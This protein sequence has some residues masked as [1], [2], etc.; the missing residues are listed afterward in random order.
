MSAAMEDEAPSVGAFAKYDKMGE[1][2][3]SVGAAAL[4]A[5]TNRYVVTEKVHGAN[6]CLIARSLGP[7]SVD[8]KFAKRTA[9][10]GGVDDAEDFYSCRSTGLLR[11]LA[12]CAEHVLRAVEARISGSNGALAVHIYGELFGGKYPHPEVPSVPGLEPVQC[13]VWYSPSLQFMAFDVCVELPSQPRQFIDFDVARHL[14]EAGGL[15]FA[16]PLCEGTLAECLDF[17]YEFVTTIPGLLGLPDMP[18]DAEEGRNVAEGV[19][20]RPRQEPSSRAS[21]SSSKGGGKESARGLFKRKIEAFSEKR[22]QNDDWRK[23]KAGGGGAAP[24]VNEDEITLIEIQ[25]CVTEQRLAAVMSKI[26]RVDPLDKASLARLL[27]DFEADVMEA[28][29][30]A[31]AGRLRQS[32]ALQEHLRQLSKELINQDFKRRG[33]KA[34]KK[35][36]SPK[37][38]A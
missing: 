20:V 19:V 17:S 13:G 33:V 37:S 10:L 16:Q 11:S 6:F 14:C 3:G 5:S 28:L 35:E 15:R 1:D 9:I 36:G 22:Y 12:P 30:E 25:A 24:T 21:A 18:E 38:S 8:L 31:D 27:S 7:A 29:E 2:S 4:S 26:G 23:G 34:A 32:V